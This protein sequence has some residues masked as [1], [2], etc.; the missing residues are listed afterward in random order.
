M[1]AKQHA[2]NMATTKNYCRLRSL[3]IIF[4]DPFAFS[5]AWCIQT[6]RLLLSEAAAKANGR[7]TES[8]FL[9]DSESSSESSTPSRIPATKKS[10]ATCDFDPRL[11]EPVETLF[12][13]L[14]GTGAGLFGA[15]EVRFTPP[16]LVE[17]GVGAMMD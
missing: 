12:L 5:T 11:A 7:V 16:F 10:D 15:D 3:S 2:R 17:G 4:L 1:I 8:I 13:W 14:F 6:V 9:H